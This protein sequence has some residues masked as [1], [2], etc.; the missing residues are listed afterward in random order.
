[1]RP[2][3]ELGADA[4]AR[5][6]GVATDLDDTLT[7]HGVLTAASLAGLEALVAN[8]VPCVI[9]T[10]RPLG[11]AEV[12]ASLCPVRAVV[13]ENGGAWAVR[14]GRGVRLAFLDDHA[15]RDEGMRRSR[16]M[17][18]RLTEVF[19][20]SLVVE[21]A[22]R[23][24]DVTLDVGER[25]TVPRRVVDE[26]VAYARAEGLHA[27]ASSVH[28]HVSYRAPD[29]MAGLRA[30]LTD[31]GL[32]ARALDARWVYLGDSPNDAGPFGA[33]ALSVGV[34]GVERFAGEMPSLPRY[35]A[36]GGAG[37]ALAE[38]AAA[39]AARGPA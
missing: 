14:E 8:N 11:W 35:V 16:D 38:V 1:V 36:R 10:G 6:E 30:A 12:L 32:D 4:W 23:M 28:L 15:V 20:L 31:L 19:P 3:G 5:V 27:V 39:L 22:A 33:M 25:V 17:A 18:R 29:K 37:E 21:S 34:R 7:A 26:A 13:A 2:L 24:T 9:A